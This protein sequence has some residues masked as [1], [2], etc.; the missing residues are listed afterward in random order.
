MN[1]FRRMVYGLGGV[2]VGGALFVA[3]AQFMS[4]WWALLTGVAVLGVVAGAV[5][6]YYRWVCPL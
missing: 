4:P 6:V 5:E 2:I 1:P 3:L